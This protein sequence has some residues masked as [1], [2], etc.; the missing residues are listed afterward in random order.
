[1]DAPMLV[2]VVFSALGLPAGA[3]ATFTPASITPGLT[4]SAFAMTI[5]TQRPTARLRGG[6][7]TSFAFAVLL[8][9]LAGSGKIRRSSLLRVLLVGLLLLGVVGGIG[10]MTGCGSFRDGFLGY[11][12]QDY[13]ITVIGTATSST[14]TTMQR[15]ATVKLTVK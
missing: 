6:G 15:I 12:P 9:P 2:P 10:I 11:P 4:A 1:M 13:T 14:G 5:Q 7:V 3:T 8:L